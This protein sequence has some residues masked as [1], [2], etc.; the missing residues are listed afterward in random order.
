M[1]DTRNLHP[2]LR[3]WLPRALA[4]AVV[5]GVIAYVV[6]RYVL[7]Q[8]YTATVTLEIIPAIN[9][10]AIV[11]PPTD[12]VTQAQ[13][14]AAVAEQ[15]PIATK[16]YGLASKAGSSTAQSKA[17]SRQSPGTTCQA[18]GVTALFSCSVSAKSGGFAADA[19]NAIA[20]VFIQHELQVSPGGYW[21]TQ[22]VSPAVAPSGPSSPHGTLNALIAFVLVFLAVLG[23]GFVD[24]GMPARNNQPDDAP[25]MA[26]REASSRPGTVRAAGKD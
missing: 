3:K 22:V 18:N 2:T 25:T 13:L 12:A 26:A 8:V 11:T 14:W 4:A 10:S 20:R 17:V 19:A 7:P 15:R 24:G 9:Q 21:G 5:C 1:M 16:G 6:S 23:Y